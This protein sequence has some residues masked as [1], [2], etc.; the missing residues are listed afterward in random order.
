MYMFFGNDNVSEEKMMDVHPL[1]KGFRQGRFQSKCEYLSLP[2]STYHTI[3]ARF[4]CHISLSLVT[5]TANGRRL[6]DVRD[7]GNH[8]AGK[9][10][11]SVS[12]AS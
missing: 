8:N 10:R 5:T 4:L 6:R 7:Q 3:L 11:K 12:R 1:V 9:N 2:R